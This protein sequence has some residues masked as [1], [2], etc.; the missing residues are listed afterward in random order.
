MHREVTI[1]TGYRIVRRGNSEFKPFPLSCSLCDCVL[2]DE[3]DETSTARSGCCFDCEHEVAD[4]N[5]ERWLAGW[6]PPLEEINEIKSRR[7]ASPH[8]RKH[9]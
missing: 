7:L 6:R 9:I 1:K 3:I 8:S 5:R 2:I 4:P